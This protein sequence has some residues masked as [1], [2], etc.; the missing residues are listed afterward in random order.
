MLSEE[1][2][3]LRPELTWKTNQ[4]SSERADGGGRRTFT[5]HV[6]PANL[7]AHVVV[8]SGILRMRQA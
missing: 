4:S 2:A 7:S 3:M 5:L 1:E 6:T 8:A